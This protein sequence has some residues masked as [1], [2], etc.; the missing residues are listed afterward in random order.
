M[1]FSSLVS[2]HIHKRDVEYEALIDSMRRLGSFISSTLSTNGY[3]ERNAYA[4]QL[5][6]LYAT[7]AEAEK[8]YRK[9]VI[10]DSDITKN[11]R[12]TYLHFQKQV[13]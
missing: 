5:E 6:E 11:Y 8:K 1:L 12:S 7:A 13:I 4:S 9:P 10:I 2:N 3:V